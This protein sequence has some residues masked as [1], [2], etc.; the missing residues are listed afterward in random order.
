MV[1]YQQIIS[2]YFISSAKLSLALNFGDLTEIR[3]LMN[4]CRF[5]DILSILKH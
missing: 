2:S 1:N 3:R 5:A 4:R